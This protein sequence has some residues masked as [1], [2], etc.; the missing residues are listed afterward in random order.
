[1]IDCYWYTAIHLGTWSEMFIK[2]KITRCYRFAP[3]LMHCVAAYVCFTKIDNR[4]NARRRTIVVAGVVTTDIRNYNSADVPRAITTLW[5][6]VMLKGDD[7]CLWR[8]NWTCDIQ[9]LTLPS[10]NLL[11]FMAFPVSPDFRSL[12]GCQNRAEKEK[13]HS[14]GW[15]QNW[16]IL[17]VKVFGFS[18]CFSMLAIWN[19]H[20]KGQLKCVVRFHNI[21]FC[22]T[23]KR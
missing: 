19:V 8:L 20:I 21:T 16:V 5:A 2:N 23:H 1:M 11:L 22:R 3:C 6:I 15:N 7:T 10:L 4:S 18:K 13:F 9:S 17:K 12:A 14:P